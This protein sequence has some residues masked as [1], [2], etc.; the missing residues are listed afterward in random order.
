MSETRQ[1]TWSAAKAQLPADAIAVA[2][3]ASR[4]SGRCC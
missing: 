1:L 3:Q 2:L 4:S